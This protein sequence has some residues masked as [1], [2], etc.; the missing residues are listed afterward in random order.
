MKTKPGSKEI[1]PRTMRERYNLMKNSFETACANGT[2]D[3]TKTEINAC[4]EWQM[5]NIL[6]KDSLELSSSFSYEEWDSFINSC[7]KKTGLSSTNTKRVNNKIGELYVKI[8]KETSDLWRSDEE[9]RRL[10][11]ATDRLNK[12]LTGDETPSKTAYLE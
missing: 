7:N 9:R 12:F 5:V 1:T 10:A 3:L 11:E 8:L 4:Y 2:R 6:I